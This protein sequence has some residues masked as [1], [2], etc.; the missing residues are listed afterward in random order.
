MM[1]VSR[2][3]LLQIVKVTSAEDLV[4]KELTLE[5]KLDISTV[6]YAPFPLVPTQ[7][8]ST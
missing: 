1:T 2:T 4:K 8:G 5:T 7:H 3:S 6:S